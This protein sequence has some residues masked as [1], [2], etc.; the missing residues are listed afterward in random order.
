MRSIFLF[1][2]DGQRAEGGANLFHYIAMRDAGLLELF[3]FLFDKIGKTAGFAH[4]R[5][6]YVAILVLFVQI[7]TD[8]TVTDGAS[9]VLH[10]L[11][12]RLAL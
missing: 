8:R 5:W 4:R 6:H 3:V 12:L 10:F 11:V 2:F 7:N 1:F 9:N